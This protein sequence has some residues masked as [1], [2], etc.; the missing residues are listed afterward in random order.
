MYEAIDYT[1]SRVLP[2]TTHSVVRCFMA[3]HQGMS[4]LGFNTVPL[5]APTQR[6]FLSD[7][8]VR[9][10][11]LLLQERVPKH[12]VIVHPRPD[13]D[14]GAAGLVA[15]EGG[16]AQPALHRPEYPA[17]LR[18][19]CSPTAATTSWPPTRAVGTAAGATWR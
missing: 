16:A 10:T 17:C 3:H 15:G 12:T 14:G 8:L 19:T 7:P 9:T 5:D 4:L 1:P 11:E 18:S 2:G 13:D 6:R